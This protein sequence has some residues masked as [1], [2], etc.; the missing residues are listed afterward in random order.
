MENI[1]IGQISAI[2]LFLGTFIGG[3]AVLYGYIKKWLKITIKE[4]NEVQSDA[5]K[6]LLRTSMVNTYYR[7]KVNK[8]IP[9]YEKESW[10]AEYESYTE[11]GGNSFIKDLKVE[12]DSWEIGE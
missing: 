11:L 7:Y 8:K 9:Y 5:I 4:E 6:S 12:I 1:T 2:V 10:Y 3:I